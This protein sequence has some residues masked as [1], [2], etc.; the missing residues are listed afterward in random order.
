MSV[1]PIRDGRPSLSD[2]PARLRLLADELPEGVNAAVVVLQMED[3]STQVYGYGDTPTR[4]CAAGIL[5]A[6]IREALPKL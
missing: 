5:S 4:Y 6:G 2:I 1:T 3:G